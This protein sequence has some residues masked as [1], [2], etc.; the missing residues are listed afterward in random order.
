MNRRNALI[1]AVNPATA[2]QLVNRKYDTKNTLSACDIPVAPTIAVATT[3]VEVR[4]L[5]DRLPSA[6]ALKP[7]RGFGGGGILLASGRDDAAWRSPGGARI[8]A[9]DVRRHAL[10]VLDGEFSMG[11]G[12][13]RVLAEPLLRPH[14]SLAAVAAGGLPDIRIITREGVARAAML[15]LPV[16]A[17]TG[18]A[19]LHQGGIG[20]SID[21]AGGHATRAVHRSGIITR[22]PDTGATLDIEIPEWLQVRSA[23]ERCGPAVG[24]GYC[25]VDVVVD[26]ERGP[27]VVEVNAR[28]G[29]EIQNVTGRGLH[30][31]VTRR[32][33]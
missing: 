19:N 2:I 26:A 33:R 21:L 6:W 16:A 12:A 17:S 30:G 22:H 11:D 28:P 13:D 15:R 31:H 7:D 25:G 3:P 23:A 29:L 20:V 1:E 18:K 14:S 10:A 4:A 32:S 5:V 9:E 8:D 24:L 27:L